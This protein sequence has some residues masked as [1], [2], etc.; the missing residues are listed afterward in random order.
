MEFKEIFDVHK[1]KLIINNW[2]F[3]QFKESNDKY[4]PILICKKYLEQSKQDKYNSN[5]NRNIR[6]IKQ[7]F[8]ADNALSLQSLKR[9]IRN[10]FQK[11]IIMILILLIVFQLY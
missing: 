11:I 8:Y 3:I 7:S 2:E 10:K 1:L 4:D 6:K 9:S 5:I